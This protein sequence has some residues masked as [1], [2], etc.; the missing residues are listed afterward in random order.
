MDNSDTRVGVSEE[1]TG[2]HFIYLKDVTAKLSAAYARDSERG[3]LKAEFAVQES[4][5]PPA[6]QLFQLTRTP[7]AIVC[8]DRDRRPEALQLLEEANAN[9]EKEFDDFRAAFISGSPQDVHRLAS[10]LADYPRFQ[11]LMKQKADLPKQAKL[12]PS[13]DSGTL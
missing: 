4:C 3:L 11:T 12:P 8:L 9:Q 5:S 10:K 13:P 6:Y 1:Q 2:P 7:R